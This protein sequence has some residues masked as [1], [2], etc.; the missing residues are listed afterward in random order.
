MDEVYRS[1]PATLAPLLG[2]HEARGAWQAVELADILAHQL[3]APL[4]FDL[5]QPEVP[6][7]AGDP[8]RAAPAATMKSFGDLLRHPAPPVEL[9]RLTKEFAKSSDG[10]GGCA[11]PAEVATVLYYAAIA[12]A[13][14]RLNVQIS[15]LTTSELQDGFNWAIRQQWIDDHTRSLFTE[16]L[17]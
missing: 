10:A 5:K 16:A 7:C 2:L 9:L 11:L 1:A 13:R 3:R 4:L 15:K 6:S 12:A 17:A 14:L 8:Q